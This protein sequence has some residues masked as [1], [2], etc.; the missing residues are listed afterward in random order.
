MSRAAVMMSIGSRLD[1]SGYI[2]IYRGMGEWW[3]QRGCIVRDSLLPLNDVCLTKLRVFTVPVCTVQCT[4][5]Y[6]V[7]TVSTVQYLFVQGSTCQ[8]STVQYLSVQYITLRYS[9]LVS[10]RYLSS[11]SFRSKINSV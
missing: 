1:I 9:N 5:Q 3:P 2:G 8:Y 10:P 7:V 6:S 4:C 11:Y